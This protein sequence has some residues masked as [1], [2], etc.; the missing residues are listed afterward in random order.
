MGKKCGQTVIEAVLVVLHGNF[1]V[2]LTFNTYKEH[3]ILL[4]TYNIRYTRLTTIDRGR[5]INPIRFENL[6][7]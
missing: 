7:L 5:L 6:P 2:H 3:R 4:H 1:Y